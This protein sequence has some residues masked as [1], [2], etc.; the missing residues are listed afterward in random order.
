MLV[1]FIWIVIASTDTGLEV[2]ANKSQC[3]IITRDQNT[4]EKFNFKI[5]NISFEEVK[6]LKYFGNKLNI[7]K[8]YSGRN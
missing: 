6:Q 4:G 3:M 8:F 1:M 5:E 7:S 2:N